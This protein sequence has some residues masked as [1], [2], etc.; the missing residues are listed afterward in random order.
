VGRREPHR[1]S[2]MLLDLAANAARRA[3]LQQVLA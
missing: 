2:R 3:L 1:S